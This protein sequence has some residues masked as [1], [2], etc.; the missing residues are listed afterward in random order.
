MISENQ[1]MK[2]SLDYLFSNSRESDRRGDE[3]ICSAYDDSSLL[4]FFDRRLNNHN[5]VHSGGGVNMF[6]YRIYI[7]AKN[8]RCFIHQIGLIEKLNLVTRPF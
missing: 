4:F 1:G 8:E 7:S 6:L 3:P 5:S 2:I